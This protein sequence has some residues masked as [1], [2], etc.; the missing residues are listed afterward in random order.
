M[1][2]RAGAVVERQ[3]EW[4]C[5]VEDQNIQHNEIHLWLIDVQKLPGPGI[6]SRYPGWLSEAEITRANTIINDAHRQLYLGGRAGLR[7][8]LSGYSGIAGSEL[9]LACQNRGKPWL[10]NTVPGGALAFNY[11]L[12]RGFALYAF[13]LD[14]VLGIDLEIFPRSIN[15]GLLAKRKL[16]NAEQMCWREI[17]A[18]QRNDAMLACWTRKEAYGKALGVGIRYAMNQVALFTDLQQDQWRTA[19]FGLF[20]NETSEEIS[21]LCGI[22]L[23]LPVPGAACL[24]YAPGVDDVDAIKGAAQENVSGHIG[25]ALQA[26]R[27]HI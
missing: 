23:A 13:A 17:P 21:Q 25:P 18:A 2:G 12:S 9:E 3:L 15:A 24:M 26:F 4:R 14:R 20:A 19:V 1:V 16:T 8:L 22:Q 7:R 11:T 6:E 27:R 5:T 10:K